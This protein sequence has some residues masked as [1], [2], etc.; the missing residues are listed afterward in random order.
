MAALAELYDEDDCL[1]IAAAKLTDSP[2]LITWLRLGAAAS[3]CLSN[4]ALHSLVSEGAPEDRTLWPETLL[5]Y[6]Q[7]RQF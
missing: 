2:T 7:H 6:Y 4:Q 3:K 1:I 5:L